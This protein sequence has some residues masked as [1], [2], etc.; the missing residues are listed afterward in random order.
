M[1]LILNIIE[2]VT[3]NYITTILWYTQHKLSLDR[4]LWMSEHAQLEQLLYTYYMIHAYTRDQLQWAVLLSDY[5]PIPWHHLCYYTM[6][7]R[8]VV[9]MAILNSTQLNL[10]QH[11]LPWRDRSWMKDMEW[12]MNDKQAISKFLLRQACGPPGPPAFC[13]APLLFFCGG[14]SSTL[15]PSPHGSGG[16]LLQNCHATGLYWG[17][18]KVERS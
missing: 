4:K 2:Q 8:V 1:L 9:P 6:L 3:Y 5:N 15:A 14:L 11:N 16:P 7:K 17:V 10:T 13:L 18:S 12:T